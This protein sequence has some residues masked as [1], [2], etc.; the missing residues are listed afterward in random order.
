MSLISRDFFLI[1]WESLLGNVSYGSVSSGSGVFIYDVFIINCF[2]ISC[3]FC[4]F[5]WGS[6]FITSLYRGSIFFNRFGSTVSVRC[7]TFC[8]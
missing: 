1:R 7:L 8:G 2:I 3:V 4:V 6:V 5:S